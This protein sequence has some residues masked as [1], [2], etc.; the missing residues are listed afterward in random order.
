MK[1]MR[2]TVV[3]G[4]FLSF[5]LTSCKGGKE[6]VSLS[7]DQRKVFPADT[8]FMVGINL[9]KISQAPIATWLAEQVPTEASAQMA[10]ECASFSKSAQL[11]FGGNVKT[12]DVSLLARYTE[13]EHVNACL[14][15]L[16]R[17]DAPLSIETLSPNSTRIGDV[18]YLH[19][20]DSS[21]VLLGEDK[22]S[23]NHGVSRSSSLKADSKMSELIAKVDRSASIWGVALRPDMPGTDFES[24]SWSISFSDV[25]LLDALLELGGGTKAS[26]FKTVIMEMA[27]TGTPRGI[28]VDVTIVNEKAL[29]LHVVISRA[30][31]EVVMGTVNEGLREEGGESLRNQVLTKLGLKQEKTRLVEPGHKGTTVTTRTSSSTTTTTAGTTETTSSTTTTTTSGTIDSLDLAMDASKPGSIEISSVKTT[32]GKDFMGDL[33]VKLDI[34][35]AIKQT[36]GFMAPHLAVQ[37]RC[38]DATDDGKAFFMGLSEAKAGSVHQDSIELFSIS[39]LKTPP[40]QCEYTMQF[41]SQSEQPIVFCYQDGK[42]VAGACAVPP[43]R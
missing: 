31:I 34:R 41:G 37:A 20:L 5:V 2:T 13:P 17:S 7:I 36:L 38:G 42:T 15:E 3:I 30:A 33:T 19:W 32:V 43:P 10:K 27:A 22:E 8:N 12:K 16:L 39:S 28:K 11:I 26:D 14:A 4:L 24:L 35:V 21:T 9:S 23:V 6:K 25:I 1:K 40:K 18:A 29:N